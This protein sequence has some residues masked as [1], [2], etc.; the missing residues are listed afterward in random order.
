[1]TRR[2]ALIALPVCVA[3]LVTACGPKSPAATPKKTI[4]VTVHATSPAGRAKPTA[5]S[6]PVGTQTVQPSTPIASPTAP[7]GPAPCQTRYLGAKAGLSQGAAGSAYVNIVFTNLLNATCTLYGYPGVS[8]GGGHPVTQ[9]GQAATENPATPREL[10]TLAPGGEAYATLR[11]VQA[12]DF[13]ASTCHPAAATYLQIIPP[14]QTGTI[15]LAYRTTACA[16]SV[17]LLTV[18]VVQPGSGG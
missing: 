9:I 10:V 8:L 11:I 16:G 3:A 13:P 15:Y 6:T 12:A 1:M 5:V 2:A 17:N 4:T 18:N 14:N 7:S